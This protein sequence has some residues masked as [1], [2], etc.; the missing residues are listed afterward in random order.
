MLNKKGSKFLTLNLRY[1]KRKFIVKV[2]RR[3][4][5]NLTLLHPKNSNLR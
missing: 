5:A 2:K 1:C 4:K 3:S